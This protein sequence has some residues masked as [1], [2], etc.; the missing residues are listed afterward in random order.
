M[1]PEQAKGITVDRRTDIFS[2]G[3]VLYEMLTGQQAFTG[4]TAGDILAAVIR[5][6]PDWTLLA[7]DVPPAIH[8][9]L[10]LCL[11]K[12]RKKRPDGHGRADRH[13]TC[14]GRTA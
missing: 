10:R 9:L 13:R 12:D 1:S 8:K 5:A 4:E 6:E 3:V 2:F 14:A 11:Q 7:P